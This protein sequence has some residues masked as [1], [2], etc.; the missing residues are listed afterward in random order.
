MSIHG[1]IGNTAVV[2]NRP[3]APQPGRR[4]VLAGRIAALAATAGFMPLHA[5][6][7]AGIPL[8]ADADRFHVWHAD[9]GGTYLWTLTALAALPAVLAFALIRPWGL[10]FP[11]WTPWGGSRV[12]RL[13]LVVPG[14]GLVVAL[15]GYALL[16]VVLT[17]VQWNSPDVIFSPWTG[18]YGIG[19][20][21][22][23]VVSLAVATRSYARRTR[24]RG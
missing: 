13:L 5:V 8:F 7:A 14:Y 20:F 22:V 17:V 19:Q 6:W 18:V 1:E 10:V 16:A 21:A 24:F 4:A 12:P 11:A 9:G 23:W 3:E 15:G 2:I